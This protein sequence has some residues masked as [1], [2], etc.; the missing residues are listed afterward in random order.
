MWASPRWPL[1]VSGL[2]NR[3]TN[4]QGGKHSCI[5][6]PSFTC[7][8]SP[9]VWTPTSPG[10]GHQMLSVCLSCRPPTTILRRIHLL[11]GCAQN[12]NIPKRQRKSPNW[13][14]NCASQPTW[15]LRAY[16][17]WSILCALPFLYQKCVETLFVQREPLNVSFWS[18]ASSFTYL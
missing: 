7:G 4:T 2:K 16:F 11:L 15:G 5:P 8:H 12:P 9:L 14:N 10:A 6:A 17:K 18:G 13:R 1:S 3:A